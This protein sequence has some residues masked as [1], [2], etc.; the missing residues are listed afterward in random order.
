MDFNNTIYTNKIAQI[1]ISKV[2]NVIVGTFINNLYTG[3]PILKLSGTPNRKISFRDS[4]GAGKEYRIR[5]K[6]ASN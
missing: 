2:P 6:Y 1:P 4:K 5:I 3:G